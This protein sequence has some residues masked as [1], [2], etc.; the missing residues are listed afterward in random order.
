M[1]KHEI[2]IQ[3]QGYGTPLGTGNDVLPYASSVCYPIIQQMYLVCEN[4]V[5]ST[6]TLRITLA[7]RRAENEFGRNN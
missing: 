6:Q 3:Y 5:A 1:G 7:L 4:M 2:R